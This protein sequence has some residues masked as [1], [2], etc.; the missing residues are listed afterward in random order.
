MLCVSI[1]ITLKHE[2]IFV[3]NLH[4]KDIYIY[5]W[6]VCGVGSGNLYLWKMENIILLLQFMK[7]M[8]IVYN[9][10]TYFYC[11]CQKMTMS[12]C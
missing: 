3:L 4:T 11:V 12:V 10:R 6:Y 5:I 2:Q 8:K 1:I 9:F 7:F